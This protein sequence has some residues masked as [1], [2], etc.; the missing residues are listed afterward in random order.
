MDNDKPYVIN[1]INSIIG[2]AIL[3][4]SSTFNSTGITLTLLILTIGALLT[5][6]SVSILI[7]ACKEANCDSYSDLCRQI[8]G[9]YG[10]LFVEIGQIFYLLG[11]IIGYYIA[12][13]D[14]L[15]ELLFGD[16]AL[17]FRTKVLAV[18]GC[19]MVQPL[20]L[21]KDITSITKANKASIC[22]YFIVTCVIIFEAV[23]SDFFLGIFEIGN[24][25]KDLQ[26]STL[27]YWDQS[28]FFNTMSLF[29]LGFS[30]HP[31]IFIVYNDL[32]SKIGKI[33]VKRMEKIVKTAIYYV[34]LL[35]TTIG[36]CG[37]L[38]FQETIHGNLLTNYSKHSFICQ[39]MRFSFCFSCIISFPI[40][41]FPARQ[42]IFELLAKV[43]GFHQQEYQTLSTELPK[44]SV[45]KTSQIPNKIFIILTFAINLL[46][47][48]TAI[49]TPN[50][51]TML[52]LTGSIAGSL[53]AFII[54]ALIGLKINSR[55]FAD[56]RKEAGC[57][58]KIQSEEKITEG[59]RLEAKVLLIAGISLFVITPIKVYLENNP[60]LHREILQFLFDNNVNKYQKFSKSAAKNL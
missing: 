35:Y 15:P 38:T 24:F 17:F 58:V 39:F 41:I 51:A 11:I 10:K 19:L 59:H 18:V 44:S 22:G 60:D 34:A 25:K 1:I 4:M 12:L 33:Q 42:A 3:A 9:K 45:S 8:L 6:S 2:V 52:T 13:G 26:Q 49:V 28:N 7:R 37:Y 5:I 32:K 20:I 46:C 57:D 55:Y 47:L 50:I 53:I 21:M 23:T 56:K 40:L 16:Q 27:K 36:L 48:Y 29:A 43:V 14:L 30:C 31:Q 54:P